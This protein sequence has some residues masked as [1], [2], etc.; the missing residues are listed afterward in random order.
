VTSFDG[1]I[2]PLTLCRYVCSFALLNADFSHAWI[3][4]ISDLVDSMA[5]TT[6]DGGAKSEHSDLLVRNRITTFVLWQTGTASS[7]RPLKFCEYHEFS[8]QSNSDYLYPMQSKTLARMTRYSI[9]IHTGCIL[10]PLR[11]ANCK[12]NP[13]YTAR[14]R[15]ER[16]RGAQK[17]KFGYRVHFLFWRV[18]WT[19]PPPFPHVRVVCTL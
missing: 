7:N 17:I 12:S 16:P 13:S 9:F 2:G 15:T 3:V 11:H 14:T 19:Y 1:K 10:H 6:S 4:S 5:S 8:A 18:V